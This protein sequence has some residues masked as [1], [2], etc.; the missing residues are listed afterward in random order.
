MCKLYRI[1]SFPGFVNLIEK[2]QERYVNP[3][4]WEDTYEGY[5]L[6]LIENANTSK[7]V[8]DFL[9]NTV[10]EKDIDVTTSN[11]TKLYGARWLCYGQSW[12]MTSE[13]DALWRIYSYDKMSVRIESSCK[14]IEDLIN[15]SGYSKEFELEIRDVKYDLDGNNLLE[16][17]CQ[18]IKDSKL[19]IEPF[20]HKRKAFEH[21]NEK[22]V[23]LLDKK[24]EI[25][26]WCSSSIFFQELKDNLKI[27]DLNDEEV[28][29]FLYKHFLKCQYPFG[30]EQL[31]TEQFVSIPDLSSY[32]TSVMVHPQAEPWIVSLVQTICEHNNL[33]F[34]G[35]SK[36]YD[37]I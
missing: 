32:I 22:R 9:Y 33:N 37:H 27:D 2:K 26:N 6:R 35:K 23:I 3:V 12:S 15:S 24:L 34:L 7:E 17:Q 29:D 1:I 19:T 10:S 25:I 18:F 21:E 20:L 4:K 5:L 31:A 14:Q 11:F 28:L 13:S 16:Q 30:D 8:I 36:L